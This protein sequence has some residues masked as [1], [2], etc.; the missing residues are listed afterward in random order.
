[1]IYRYLPCIVL[2]VLL[3]AVPTVSADVGFGK[4]VVVRKG[5]TVDEAVSFGDDVR[6]FGTVD[7]DAVSFGGDVIIENGG[8]VRK[9]AISFG[10]DVIVKQNGTVKDAA[11]LG[12]EVHVRDGGT[13]T[14]KTDDVTF[15]PIPH[16]VKSLPWSFT[17]G[18]PNIF[19]LVFGGPLFGFFGAAGFAIGMIILF[20]K[21]IVSMAFAAVVTYLFPGHVSRM[22]GF[23][24]NELP[25][26]I[27]AGLVFTILIPVAVLMLII[28]ILGI[29][30]VPILILA[31]II[32]YI[33]G[34]AG[35]ALWIGRIIPE[36]EGRTLM[37]NVML[38]VLAISVVKFLPV[39]GGIVGIILWMCAIGVVLLT[40]FGSGSARA[41]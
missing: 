24:Q 39:V 20:F 26:S 16:I 21:L 30:I 37:V 12:G 9:Q 18:F 4:E 13:I 10:G 40:R 33:F 34:T 27:V 7:G 2:V 29:P 8:K 17:N 32:G 6:V 22:A 35:I 1:M 36:S 41:V 5:S 3:A 25:K 19:R 38:G 23:L 28:S 14:G 31:I 11:S 15:L